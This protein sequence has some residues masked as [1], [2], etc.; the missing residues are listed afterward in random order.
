[1]NDTR[2]ANARGANARG[3]NDMNEHTAVERVAKKLLDIENN[4]KKDYCDFY[5]D[6]VSVLHK[7][8][9][10]IL[11]VLMHKRELNHF[12]I[13]KLTL[14]IEKLYLRLEAVNYLGYEYTITDSPSAYHALIHSLMDVNSKCKLRVTSP[15]WGNNSPFNDTIHSYMIEAALCCADSI[16][17]CL[18][19][20]ER[21]MCHRTNYAQDNINPYSRNIKQLK[22]ILY[23]NEED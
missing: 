17:C 20:I 8:F 18:K 19:Y 15:D 3:A 6:S 14:A 10:A 21:L 23:D 12:D 2:G 7:S 16:L 11:P 5:S 4:D 13:I 9:I 1:M 22:G